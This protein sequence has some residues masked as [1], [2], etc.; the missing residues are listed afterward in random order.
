MFDP[1][2]KAIGEKLVQYCQ[3]GKE[4][5]ALQELYAPQAVSAE[6]LAMP[7]MDSREASG[8]DAI[9]AK[10]EWWFGAHEVHETSAEGPFFHGEDKFGVIFAMDV[11]AKESGERMQARELGLYTVENG[12]IVR[13]EFFYNM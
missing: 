4:A 12:K 11:T 1:Q 2:L 9:K 6:P 7:G 5:E 8:L 13:E 3:E 10:H